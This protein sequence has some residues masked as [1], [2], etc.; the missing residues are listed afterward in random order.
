MDLDLKCTIEQVLY[1]FLLFIVKVV[2]NSSTSVSNKVENFI[3]P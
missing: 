1:K 3:Y 2:Y